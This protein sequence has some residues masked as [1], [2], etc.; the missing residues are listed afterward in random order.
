MVR[1]GMGFGGM[2]D[3]VGRRREREALQ[4]LGSR[5]GRRAIAIVGEPGIGKTSLWE[6]T[7]E[8]LRSEGVQVRTAR[9]AEAEAAFSF[10][11]LGDILAGVDERQLAS[12]PVP[13]R[14]ALAAALLLDE[15]T[16]QPKPFAVAAGFLGLL[17]Q[18]GAK[19]PVVVAVDD[20]QW[21]DAASAD[22]LQYA[23]RRASPDEVRFLFAVRSAVRSPIDLDR[24]GVERLELG[25]LTFGAI[26]HLIAE[27][28]ELHLSRTIA[29]RIYESTNGNPFF[30]LELGRAVA[31]SGAGE[32]REL[33]LPQTVLDALDDRL[34]RLPRLAER[35]VLAV[36]L[37]A[38]LTTDRLGTVV[39]AADSVQAAVDAGVLLLSAG[40][41]RLVH[42]L[43]GTA[44]AGRADP[45]TSRELSGRLAA[46]ATDP[47]ERARHL[48]RSLEPPDEMVAVELEHASARA[49]R[50]GAS[51]A[52]AELAVAALRFAGTRTS[53]GRLLLVAAERVNDT[54]D[55]QTA[56]E[57]ARR[58]LDFVDEG[59]ARATALR[60]MCHATPD[61]E[62]LVLLDEALRHARSDPVVTARLLADKAEVLSMA[63]VTALDEAAELGRRALALLGGDGDEEMAGVAAIEVS[64]AV[65]LRGE[66]I[67]V[68]LARATARPPAVHDD[69]DR[70]RAMRAMWRGEIPLARSLLE[71][72]VDRSREV[73]EVWSEFV[74]LHHLLELAIRVGDANALAEQIEQADLQAAGLPATT[75]ALQRARV[76]LAA[77]RGQPEQA[78]ELARSAFVDENS[79]RWQE[80]ESRRGVGLA[81][82]LVGDAAAAAASLQQ[83]ADHVRASQVLEPGAFPAGADLVE[84]L[85]A[86]GRREQAESELCW[87]EERAHEQTHPWA[88][89]TSVRARGVLQVADGDLPAAER[90]FRTALERHE[91]LEL[92]LDE[93]RA[94]LALGRALRQSGR[95]R[96]ARAE[97]GAAV[98]S[99]EALGVTPLAAAA[100]GELGRLGGR[101]RSDGLTGT[102]ERVARLVVDGLTNRE[103]AERLFVSVRAV[104]ANLT[105]VYAKLGVRSRVELARAL[106][107]A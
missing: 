41:A 70:S 95:R 42:P 55:F 67:E 26:Q 36:A 31:E 58:A 64:H 60:I 9:P 59:V 51:A 73:G 89:A 99:L 20:L 2:D 74:Y 105:R 44:V 38:N 6:T 56:A 8:Q 7:V 45:E 18:L 35:A 72:L 54:G 107:D 100:R 71:T 25:G 37:G 16:E 94:R 23:L 39:G 22:A 87:L 5:T 61:E 1:L 79:S 11:T 4:A 102:E 106:G 14:D 32:D 49:A 86:L 101:I 29:R 103:V 13:Q 84:A 65:A 62:A 92:P 68:I 88:L 33:P 93:A 91:A 97:L 21:T 28:L 43:I 83:V 76:F 85:A 90:S 34:G 47:E 69:P 75:P 24:S 27:R 96:D 53:E 30:A 52:A 50:R 78:E 10:S 57:L 40:R 82:L 19:A 66:D 80:L 17:R 46:T 104:E 12:L 63:L 15:G 81:R 77:F 48:A 3:L 98:E